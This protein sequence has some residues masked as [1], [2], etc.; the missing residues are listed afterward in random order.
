M[1]KPENIHLSD[2]LNSLGESNLPEGAMVP[3]IFQ[4]SNF[5]FK[6]IDS[7]RHAFSSEWDHHLYT[8]GNNPT[9]SILRKKLA[10]LE[11][12]EDALCFSSGIAAISAAIMSQVKQGDHVICVDN[13][14]SWTNHLLRNYLPKFGV[15]TSFVNGDLASIESAARSSTR[16][17]MLESP[18]SMTF[19]LQDLR[20]CSEWA[21]LNDVVTIIDNS[22]A[23]PLYQKPHKLGIDIV[24]HSGSKYLNGHGDVVFGVLCASAATVSNIVKDEYMTFGA[25]MSPIEAFLVLRGLRTL[26][27]RMDRIYK[28]TLSIFEYLKSQ[29]NV[30]RIYY[31]FDPDSEQYDLA[32]SQMSASPGLLSIQLKY[33][34]DQ[35]IV[36]F[37]ESLSRFR[38]AVSWGGHESLVIPVLALYDIADR[39]APTL[40]RNH[41]RFYIG[42]EQSELLIADLKEAFESVGKKH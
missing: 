22:Y 33:S 38:M 2:I 19:E 36:K 27:I 10:A 16:L 14:Y 5:Q 26:E 12:T 18:N 28:N 6:T 29:P 42:L 21:K 23:S 1:K 9:V 40:P 17:L 41:V 39:P 25:I 31:P 24:V 11:E 3:P 13:P 34:K 4:T 30:D 8:R 37:C 20:A 32:R 35:D 7:L 15:S